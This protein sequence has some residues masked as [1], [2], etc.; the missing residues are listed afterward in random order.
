MILLIIVLYALCSIS[1]AG[2]PEQGL[3]PEHSATILTLLSEEELHNKDHDPVVAAD[4]EIGSPAG[5]RKAINRLYDTTEGMN[6]AKLYDIAFASRIMQLLY[7]LEPM[8]WHPVRLHEPNRYLDAISQVEKGVYPTELGTDTF[9]D[10]IIPSL[11]L[12]KGNHIHERSGS[13][14]NRLL[15]AQTL[16][17]ASV[18]PPYLLGLLYEDTQRISE[19]E[20]AYR[21]AWE[22]DSS[23]YPAG[24]RYV[25]M[26]LLRN[27]AEKAFEIAV[28]LYARY[29]ASTGMQ[30]LFADTAIATGNYQQA[31]PVVQTLLQ[32][33]SPSHEALFLK[34]RIHIEKKEYIPALALLDGYAKKNKTEKKYLLLRARILNEWSKNTIEAKRCLEKAEMLYPNA[35]D[36]LLACAQLCFHNN[37]TINGKAAN[38]FISTLLLQD[39]E[40]SAAL[41]ILIQQDIMQERWEQAFN[42]AEYVYKLMPS[43]EHR[44]LYIQTGIGIK[45]WNHAVTAAQEAYTQTEK[46]SDSL[47]ALYL[48]AL[49]GKQDYTTIN[50]VIQKKLAGA[51]SGLKAVLY[52]YQA[53]LENNREKK[54]GLLR[55]SLLSNPR[56]EK[57][58]YA[59]HEWYYSAKD[60]RKAQYYLQQV[61]ALNP[62]NRYYI[63]QSEK[64]SGLLAK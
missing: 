32:Q 2:T 35:L 42:R 47:T 16:N 49:Y 10:A 1:C 20:A 34:V 28:A 25:Q 61:L 51:R 5:I 29:P 52:Y 36:V 48:E 3:Q 23:C 43:E 30:V 41:R 12:I 37:E 58:L 40:N 15:R 26:L 59:L 53:L 24:I 63:K 17:A 9:W 57:T 46:P 7:P 50:T 18:L 14:E 21:I 45:N 4:L 6:K 13:I 64:L 19:A 44:L 60:Y 31:E 56:N 33:S 38:D 22:R 55:L 54:L 27:K 39:S 11:I 62:K 8:Q